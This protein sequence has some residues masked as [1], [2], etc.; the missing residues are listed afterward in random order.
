MS[1]EHTSAAE[2]TPEVLN[3]LLE[4]AEAR[5]LIASAQANGSVAAEE[6]ATAASDLELDPGQLETLYGLL[7]ELQI[8]IVDA[9]EGP[10]PE[11]F[12]ADT[13]E[14]STTRFSSS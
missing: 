5:E 3:E 8:E 12:D 14:V 7:D 1:A 13:R 9:P 10:A 6:L 11:A 4:H 2:R